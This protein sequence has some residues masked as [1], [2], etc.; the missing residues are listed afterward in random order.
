MNVFLTCQ[1]VWKMCIEVEQV[2]A[3]APANIMFC[4][5]NFLAQSQHA[6]GV[7]L[8]QWTVMATAFS[9]SRGQHMGQLLLE[10]HRHRFTIFLVSKAMLA[11]KS[12]VRVHVYLLN[13]RSKLNILIRISFICRERQNKKFITFPQ[14]ITKSLQPIRES[15]ATNSVLNKHWN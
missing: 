11:Y 1:T 13:A 10:S 2:Q 3:D 12:N 9:S 15:I 14:I 5:T 4:G 8:L 7:C 6:T